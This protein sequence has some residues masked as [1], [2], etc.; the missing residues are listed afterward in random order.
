MWECDLNNNKDF[1]KFLKD[2]W[3]REVVEPLNPRDAF[4]G[5]RTNATKLLYEFKENECGKYVDFCSLYPTVMF[6]NTYP[7][8]HPEKIY[9]PEVFNKDWYGLIKCKVSPPKGLY[10][11]VLPYRVKCKQAEKLMFPLC[12]TCAENKSQNICTHTRN[13]R[14]I[15]GT[16]TTDEISKAVEK[17]YEIEKLKKFLKFGISKIE[18]AKCSVST[19][20]HL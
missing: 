15:I 4:Y 12:K 8:G 9:N 7:I 2:K 20:K 18:V 14:E 10:H 1:Q 16:W 11:P 5:G 3:T 17:G 13:E 19:S 6:Y